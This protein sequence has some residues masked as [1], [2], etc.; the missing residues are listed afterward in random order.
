MHNLHQRGITDLQALIRSH[1]GALRTFPMPKTS[2]VDLLIQVEGT[3]PSAHSSQDVWAGVVVKTISGE[4]VDGRIHFT[5][6]PHQRSHLAGVIFDATTD[7][8]WFFCP[9]VA[10]TELPVSRS[11]TMRRTGSGILTDR[12]ERLSIARRDIPAKLQRFCRVA[13]R[14]TIREWLDDSAVSPKEQRT[15][16]AVAA[17]WNLIYQPCGFNVDFATTASDFCSVRLNGI[18]VLNRLGARFDKKHYGYTCKLQ[19]M[20]SRVIQPFCIADE[21]EFLCVI[22]SPSPTD[23]HGCYLFPKRLL[24]EHSRITS[25]QGSG[26]L[27]L[28]VYPPY[29]SSPG[30][31]AQRW[32]LPYYIDFQDTSE[33]ALSASREK[34]MRI[35]KGDDFQ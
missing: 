34:F 21:F 15:N 1:G 33:A 31:N 5:L 26:V 3:D 29:V 22:V 25:D 14:R 28:L 23:V 24:A 18:P 13:R 8:S 30:A 20:A 6:E 10:A 19:R 4:S 32:Q 27:H 12:C 2:Y 9:E 17:M 11:V 16:H 35:L 7:D